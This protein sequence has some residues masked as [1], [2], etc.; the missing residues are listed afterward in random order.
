[1]VDSLLWHNLFKG[2]VINSRVVTANRF[3]HLT[4]CFSD[5]AMPRC[6]RSMHDGVPGG[7]HCRSTAVIRT[8]PSGRRRSTLSLL[9]FHL[10][11]RHARHSPPLGYRFNSVPGLRNPI[12]LSW[13]RFSRCRM[14]ALSRF[15]GYNWVLGVCDHR[16]CLRRHKGQGT[17]VH[18][19]PNFSYSH[20]CRRALT[21]RASRSRRLV[22]HQTPLFHLSRPT[23]D[24]ARTSTPAGS[25][26]QHKKWTHSR[27]LSPLR[28]LCLQPLKPT[29]L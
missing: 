27:A 22:P 3:M 19:S 13:R 15:R 24:L 1:M 11:I 29:S 9:S 10:A 4:I 20:H 23:R 7:M 2:G 5:I 16:F 21:I 17:V 25:N 14:V 6:L 8:D 12:V 26:I 28:P 18:C